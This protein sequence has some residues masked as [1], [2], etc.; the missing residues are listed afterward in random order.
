MPLYFYMTVSQ[1]SWLNFDHIIRLKSSSFPS[2]LLPSRQIKLRVTEVNT[3][4]RLG[5]LLAHLRRHSSDNKPVK[6]KHVTI[7]FKKNPFIHHL[8]MMHSEPWETV[9]LHP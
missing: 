7:C 4:G 3:R 2:R 5:S 9:P 1:I 8:T 6:N